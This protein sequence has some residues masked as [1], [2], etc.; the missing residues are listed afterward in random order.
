M[1]RD[2]F[3]AFRHP[4]VLRFAFGRLCSAMATN[5]V[6]V[7]VGWQLYERTHSAFALGLTGLVELVPV[8]LLFLPAGTLADRMPRRTLA[9]GAHLLMASCAAALAG[10]TLLEGPI[11][12]Y[13]VVLAFTGV[14]MAFRAPSVGPML[15]ALVPKEDFG[16]AN[17]WF[18]STFE[19]AA[20]AG[21][22]LGGALI[23]WFTNATVAFG[24]AC[25]AHLGFVAV[26][27]SLPAHP[28]AHS[29]RAVHLGDMLAGLRFVF[30][31]K[32]FL[33][34]ITLDL[35][36]VL[37]GGATALLPIFA[38]DILYAGPVGLGWLR[39]A[40]ALGAFSMA[41]L[42]TRLPPWKRPGHTLL[43][44]VVGFGLATVGFGLS[45]SFV[46]SFVMLFFIGLF[47]NVSVVI[48]STLEQALTPDA[49]RGRVSSINHVFIGLSNELG[50]FESGSTAALFG[51]VGS[52][53]GGGLGTL[54][55]VL[56]VVVAWPQLRA[57]APLHTLTPLPVEEPTP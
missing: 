10:L 3:A 56:L 55:V 12:L 4:G 2:S 20:M 17:A 5:I 21:P 44:T 26:L 54:L 29:G 6:S 36:G 38:K 28:P 30:S 7:A 45:K 42:Q 22:A 47:D 15:P 49:M 24:V 19:L 52:V 41:L 16:N 40:P 33:A 37:F 32:V 34:A 8:L 18:S 13:Y 25:A 31:A 43:S 53:V 9:I 35:F 51:A 27:A 48:R 39:A 46:L 57:L 11:W 14:A 1:A 50:S 23:A